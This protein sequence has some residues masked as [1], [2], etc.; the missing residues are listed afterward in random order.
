MI[1][2]VIAP[3]KALEQVEWLFIAL[4]DIKYEILRVKQQYSSFD[5][6][7]KLKWIQMPPTIDISITNVM[8]ACR[9]VSTVY[10]WTFSHTICTM[11]QL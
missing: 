8:H 6:E 3:I 10:I 5:T 1:I 2:L 7:I 4:Y 9:H 11:H